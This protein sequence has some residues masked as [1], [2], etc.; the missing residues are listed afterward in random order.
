MSKRCGK[1][2]HELIFFP[3]EIFFA[4]FE[5]LE[6]KDQKFWQC[7]YPAAFLGVYLQPHRLVIRFKNNSTKD[8]R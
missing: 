7:V 6:L 4:E 8:G 5:S 2:T 3:G 1:V